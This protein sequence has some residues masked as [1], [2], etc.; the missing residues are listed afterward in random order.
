MPFEPEIRDYVDNYVKKHLPRE[1]AQWYIDYFSFID[2]QQLMTKLA[3]EF[4]A[5]QYMY[6]IFEGLKANEWLQVAQVKMQIIQYASIYEAVIHHLLFKHMS[7]HPNVQALQKQ[8]VLKRI[9]VS[10]ELNELWHDGKKIITT[11]QAF[12][13]RDIAKVRFDEKARVF[14]DLGFINESLANDIILLYSHRN[15]VHLHAEIRKQLAYELTLS[16]MAYR[17]MLPFKDQ[18]CRQLTA[19]RIL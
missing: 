2:D 11:Y 3:H 4:L 14:Q 8:Q 18:V 5:T 6:K 10:K 13:V 9:S 1:G 19:I 15:A 16:R 7:F 12:E 17:R